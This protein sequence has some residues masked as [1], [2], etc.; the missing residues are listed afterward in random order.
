MRSM[1]SI[2][3]ESLFLGGPECH[4]VDVDDGSTTTL[5]AAVGEV[6][7]VMN[8]LANGGICELEEDSGGPA[9]EG[10]GF[11]N[12]FSHFVRLFDRGEVGPIFSW[13]GSGFCTSFD[14]P[15]NARKAA[16]AE[17]V[18]EREVSVAVE[19]ILDSLRSL[20]LLVNPDI[21]R[22]YS[23]YKYEVKGFSRA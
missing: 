18:W 9:F 8:S 20:K 10:D 7:L 16:I 1:R 5:D 22:I 13:D 21:V 11:S 2:T 12:Y 15:F 14:C 19:D 3:D 4:A 23:K 17:R 6:G